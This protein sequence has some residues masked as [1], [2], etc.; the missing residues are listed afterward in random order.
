MSVRKN[1]A[2]TEYLPNKTQTTK[3]TSSVTSPSYSYT[4]NKGLNYSF[5]SIIEYGR[6][7][8]YGVRNHERY[9]RDYSHRGYER[10]Y[11][12]NRSNEK[13]S[14]FGDKALPIM[15]GILFAS[16]LSPQIGQMVGGI[17]KGIGNLINGLFGGIF[18]RKDAVDP[19]SNKDK[20]V[21]TKPVDTKQVDTKEADKKPVDQTAPETKAQAVV[22]QAVEAVVQKQETKTPPPATTAYKV[23]AGDTLTK[24]IAGQNPTWLQQQIQDKVTEIIS[25]KANNLGTYESNFGQ[26]IQPE[27]IINI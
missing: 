14:S 22:Q 10:D 9:E 23:K 7:N 16:K 1:G 11:D 8:H 26:L 21:D 6:R 19:N 13:K 18:G 17:G 27:Q 3:S 20:N 24:I 4:R 25:N 15:L 12:D 5:N 2:F